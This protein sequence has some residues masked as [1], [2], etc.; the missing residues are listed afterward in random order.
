MANPSNEPRLTPESQLADSENGGTLQA[1][2]NQIAQ[3]RDEIGEINRAMA[4][5]AASAGTALKTQAQGV[6]GAVRDNPGTVSSA[7]ILGGMVGLVAG[8]I[9]GQNGRGIT[10]LHRR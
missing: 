8:L 4:N 6:S 10:W 5:R 3:L 7:F 9:L 2:Q 1:L